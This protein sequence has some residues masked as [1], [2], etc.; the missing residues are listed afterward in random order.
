MP[1]VNIPDAYHNVN[2]L[3]G[4]KYNAEKKR[5]EVISTQ[6]IPMENAAVGHALAAMIDA[7][8][9]VD[10][11]ASFDPLALAIRAGMNAAGMA[12]PE[13]LGE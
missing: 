7:F 8:A 4:A 9:Q 12:A 2:D 3:R 13:V 1:Q 6:F 11:D 5:V 10:Q